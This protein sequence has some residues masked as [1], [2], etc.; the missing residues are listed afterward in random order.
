MEILVVDITREDVHFIM[1]YKDH[2]LES[3][4]II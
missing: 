2:K 4:Q 3:I 1:W